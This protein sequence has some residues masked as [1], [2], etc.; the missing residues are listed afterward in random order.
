MKKPI[1]IPP[2]QDPIPLSPQKFAELQ[3]EVL[4]LAKERDAASER[5]KIAREMGDLSENGAY[6]YG[7]QELASY[8]R[9]LRQVQFLLKYGVVTRSS[10]SGVVEF[11]STVTVSDGKN[12]RV[13]S[14]V[15]QYE[16]DPYTGKISLES[17]I[18]LALVGK[19]VGDVVSITVPAGEIKYKVLKIN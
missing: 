17:P 10:H 18:G 4:R 5:V 14:I 15:S 16:S 2:K 8:S 11:G 6:H 19:K 7:K 1:Y 3:L 13:Y 9:Q 12:E